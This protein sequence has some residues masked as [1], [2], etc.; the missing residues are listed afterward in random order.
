MSQNFPEDLFK[1]VENNYRFD[2]DFI[3]NCIA[4]TDEGRFF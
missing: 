2:K 3:E 1:W 4:D